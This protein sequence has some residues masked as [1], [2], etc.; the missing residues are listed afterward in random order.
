M[1][2]ATSLCPG[3]LRPTCDVIQKELGIDWTQANYTDLRKPLY[4]ALAAVL[5]LE[6]RLGN[7]PNISASIEEQADLWSHYYH[8]GNPV[9][10]YSALADEATRFG[11]SI[12]K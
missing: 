1:F 9:R 7:P 11:K 3:V 10:N 5:Y 4:S 2:A 6:S 12:L 8:F